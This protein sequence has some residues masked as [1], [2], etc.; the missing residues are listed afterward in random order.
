MD[1]A[2]RV[3]L[4]TGGASGLGEATTRHLHAAGAAV[5]VVDR[6]ADRG[7]ALAAELGE[8]V[9]RIGP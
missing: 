9:R 4:V 5:A 3:A 2:G 6:D 7:A 1:V 8:D